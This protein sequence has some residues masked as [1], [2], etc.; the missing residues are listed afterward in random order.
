MNNHI[1]T[2]KAA[3]YLG[4]H[5]NTLRNARCS[6]RLSGVEGP[7][8]RKIGSRAYYSLSDLNEWLGQFGEIRTHNAKAG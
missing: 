4:L 6:G 3:K 2:S 1:N 5:P 8:F 7:P